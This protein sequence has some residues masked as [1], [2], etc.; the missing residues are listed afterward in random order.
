MR[1]TLKLDARPVKKWPYWLNPKYNQKVKEEI[2]KMVAASII[3]LVEQ[4]DW[5][6]PMV[7]QENKTIGDIR[8]YVDLRKMN[9]A[10]VHDPFPT[11]FSDEILDNVGGQEAYS[12]TNGFSGYHQIIISPEYHNKTTFATEWGSF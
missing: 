12:F 8:I 2:Y 6:I 10:C 1:I 4:S 11:P 5:V 9:D 3:E 7:V